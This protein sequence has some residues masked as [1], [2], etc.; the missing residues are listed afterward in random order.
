[1][2]AAAEMRARAGASDRIRARSDGDMETV[3]YEEA[4]TR[5]VCVFDLPKLYSVSEKESGFTYA[6]ERCGAGQSAHPPRLIYTTSAPGGLGSSSSSRSTSLAVSK[7]CF[8][9]SRS[10]SRSALA[11]CSLSPSS[12]GSPRARLPACEPPY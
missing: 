11:C 3:I 1:M 9:R 6:A 8:A 10:A 7:P 2:S 12:G 4:Y 5:R